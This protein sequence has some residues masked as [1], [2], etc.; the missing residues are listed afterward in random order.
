LDNSVFEFPFSDV[1][2]WAALHKSL[3]RGTV[4]INITDPF[5]DPIIDYGAFANLVDVANSIVMIKFAI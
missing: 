1:A 2:A 3:S 5:G 4:S